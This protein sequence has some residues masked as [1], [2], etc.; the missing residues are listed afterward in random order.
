MPII[1]LQRRL[2]P[3]G[4][5]RIG[6]TVPTSKGRGRPVKLT[7][8]RFTSPDLSSIEAIARLYGGEVEPWPDAPGGPQY[9]VT[10]EAASIPVLIPPSGLSFSQFYETWSGGGCT[11]RCD[12]EYQ[13]DDSPCVCDPDNRECKPHTRLSLIL[14][15]L[16]G[17][18]V[19][20]LDTQ[21]YYAA[22]ELAA[23]VDLIEGLRGSRL[24]E[25]RLLL[26]QRS[27][28]RPGEQTKN[29]AVPCLDLDLNVAEELGGVKSHITPIQRPDEIPALS[30]GEQLSAVDN[31]DRLRSTRS[32]AAQALPATGLEPRSVEQVSDDAAPA[33]RMLVAALRG[34][35]VSDADQAQ[36]ASGML[37]KQVADLADL[38]KDEIEELVQKVRSGLAASVSPE[39]VYAPG[40]EPFE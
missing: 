18:G 6:E 24:V 7:T 26:Q 17:I 31:P 12:G 35:K 20:R 5:I 15:D 4:R 16:D 32:N 36:W 29:F 21:G 28:K 30:V 11:R 3:A 33:R 8:F 13:T 39:P 2:R 25:G 9:Q 19:W 10:T 27:V 40:E 14:R 22:T 1:N 38:D 23:V 37:G 34:V